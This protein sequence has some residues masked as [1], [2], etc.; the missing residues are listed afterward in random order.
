MLLGK[1]LCD[2]YAL[3]EQL[4]FD[5]RGLASGTGLARTRYIHDDASF[6]LGN[7]YDSLETDKNRYKNKRVILLIRDPADTIVS[8]YFQ[9]TRR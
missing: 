4:I 8:H 9:A 5:T 2:A 6:R 7:H 1:A 3:D